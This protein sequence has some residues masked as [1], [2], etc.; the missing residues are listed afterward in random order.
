MPDAS[1]RDTIG[2]ESRASSRGRAS[3]ALTATSAHLNPGGT[4]H[5]GVLATMVDTAM[6]EALR[7]MSEDG[8]RPVTI[9]LKLNYLEPGEE[10][11]ILANA[12]VKKRGRSFTVVTAEVI[13]EGSGE[14][15]AEAMGTFT[16]VG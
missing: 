13:Q 12:E 11:L 7:T 14:S 8:E 2:I 5:G 4:V 3:V 15:L 10:G 1:F 9:E 6:G 16:T